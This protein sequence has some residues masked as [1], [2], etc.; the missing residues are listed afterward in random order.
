M[1]MVYS[2]ILRLI[3]FSLRSGWY[4]SRSFSV[5][6]P[7]GT[8]RGVSW[9]CRYWLLRGVT[10]T[11]GLDVLH[12]ALGHG[13]SVEDVGTLLGDSLVRI[14]Q[15]WES[16]DIIFLQ[17]VPLRVAEH[18]AGRRRKDPTD[19]KGYESALKVTPR[20]AVLVLTTGARLSGW[21]LCTCRWREP[22]LSLRGRRSEPGRCWARTAPSTAAGRAS[23][24]PARTRGSPQVWLSTVHLSDRT[25]AS[26]KPEYPTSGSRPNLLLLDAGRSKVGGP[27]S[28]AK[29][30]LVLA[31]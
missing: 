25:T 27:Q 20:S 8:S 4:S 12:H 2:P 19:Y 7:P 14:G 31:C 29:G 9:A 11:C 26:T 17:N 28:Q 22:K 5:M 16:D 24:G 10:E 15:L 6:I 23:C 1:C 21:T 3:G 13:A 30:L 18:R